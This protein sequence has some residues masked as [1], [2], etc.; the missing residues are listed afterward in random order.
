MSVHIKLKFKVCKQLLSKLA[1]CNILKTY[2]TAFYKPGGK[3]PK[4]S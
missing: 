2:F 1:Q 3:P 4:I